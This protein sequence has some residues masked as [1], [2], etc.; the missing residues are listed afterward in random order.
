MDNRSIDTDSPITNKDDDNFGRTKFVEELTNLIENYSNSN[1]S[2]KCLTMD[3]NGE[4]GEGKT[5]VVNLLKENFKNN[6]KY[7]FIDFN[8]WSF[9]SN[10]ENLNNEL[11]KI[12]ISNI[13]KQL[14]FSNILS[15]NFAKCFE[16]FILK[17][18]IRMQKHKTIFVFIGI[19]SI[20]FIISLF[21]LN[22]ILQCNKY[23]NFLNSFIYNDIFYYKLKIKCHILS[24]IKF[25]RENWEFLAFIIGTIWGF[26]KYYYSLLD[27]KDSI[28]PLLEF[29]N[30]KY[31][32]VIDDIDRLNKNEVIGLFNF[33]KSNLDLDNFIFIFLYERNLI[34]TIL[35]EH[36]K[37]NSFLEKI[38]TLQTDLPDIKSYYLENYFGEHLN[39]IVEH[40][41]D[42]NDVLLINFNIY[43][44]SKII[45]SIFKKN[46]RKI[47]RFLNQF[48]TDYYMIKNYELDIDFE[49][50]LFIEIIKHFEN[51]L[52]DFIK[53]NPY[54]FIEDENQNRTA[55]IDGRIIELNEIA[56]EHKYTTDNEK[57]KY[58][59]NENV[60]F[61]K[62]KLNIIK[63]KIKN[64]EHFTTII[65][66]V[67]Y[68]FPYT[69][70][71]L[72]LSKEKHPYIRETWPT[73]KISDY[74]SFYKYFELDINIEEITQIEYNNLK[75]CFDNYEIFIEKFEILVKQK[76][77]EAKDRKLNKSIE[78]NIIIDSF[79]NSFEKNE[80]ENFCKYKNDYKKIENLMVIMI[81]LSYFDRYVFSPI[82][83]VF[84]N[85]LGYQKKI[86]NTKLFALLNKGIEYQ[87]LNVG[88]QILLINIYLYEDINFNPKD[89][90]LSELRNN[91]KNIFSIIYQDGITKNY[92]NQNF[93]YQL[94]MMYNYIIKNEKE[95]CD[96][97]IKKCIMN[98]LY[99][100]MQNINKF[101][102]INYYN[103]VLGFFKACLHFSEYN[104]NF[105]K[106]FFTFLRN[107][108][109]K[110]FID[111]EKSN[112]F[113]NCLKDFNLLKEFNEF[114]LNKFINDK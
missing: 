62:E 79:F 18:I 30:I 77:D 45:D 34:D 11:Y 60:E 10:K 40:K 88:H 108:S 28:K 35:K 47:K 51:E 111:K 9:S 20:F 96:D 98:Y 17:I 13:K 84:A 66:I 104:K 80:I 41:F 100:I 69:K 70:N 26:S 78:K 4:W 103:F 112:V 49:N 58:F 6:K 106:C 33:I 94:W 89:E 64:K 87:L 54:E 44:G 102:D 85:F 114:E 93:V 76:Q 71:Y 109:F 82:G 52:Y 15:K 29:S 2:K 16:C 24:I 12:I 32:L 86:D 74:K 39:K 46:I 92:N 50:F 56:N 57:N 19:I 31:I 42:L 7:K 55:P 73:N 23:G 91:I 14:L 99:Y 36:Y 110:G 68:L 101:I 113:E 97:D 83:K 90:T 3:I 63:E 48:K 67:N 38:I 21:L 72:N 95:I 75:E 107:K 81:Y 8:P 59:E 27:K 22:D 105:K 53:N 5:S 43:L 61:I 37:Q 1:N 65:I 25:F